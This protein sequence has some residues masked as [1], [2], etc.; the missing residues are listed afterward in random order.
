MKRDIL[1]RVLGGGVMA[2]AAVAIMAG[3][4]FAK[5]EL[6]VYTAV[7][8]DDLKRYATEF[9]KVNPDIEIK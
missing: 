1:K 2:A 9:E 4:V 5:T 3:S 8:A 6:T 7:E